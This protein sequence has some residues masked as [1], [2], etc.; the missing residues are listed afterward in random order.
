MSEKRN[1]SLS[2]SLQEAFK[3]ISV[4]IF[5]MLLYDILFAKYLYSFLT[6]VW[7][8][9][10]SYS[11]SAIQEPINHPHSHFIAP[12]IS[13]QL[14][15][16][17]PGPTYSRSISPDSHIHS[18]QFPV[19]GFCRI[20]HSISSTGLKLDTNQVKPHTDGWICNYFTYKEWDLLSFNSL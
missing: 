5:K 4:K 12:S 13:N 14:V 10:N 17:N 19:M 18:I 2:F 20:N 6:K 1:T 11:T 7:G 9:I 15:I 8:K 3:Y 16:K